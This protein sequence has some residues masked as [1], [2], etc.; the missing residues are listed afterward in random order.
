M[1]RNT[2]LFA[3]LA[4]GGLQA[5][6]R[7]EREMAFD[8]DPA[9]TEIDFTLGDLLHTVHGTF[10][11]KSGS[12]RLDPATQKA[13]GDITVDVASGSSGSSARDRKMHNDILQSQTYPEAVFTPR[14]FEGELV[15]SGVS[16]LK[17][18]GLFKIHGA[19]HEMTLPIH[20]ETQ[21]DQATATAHF[22]VPY[23]KWG[24]KNPSTFILRV[25][26]KVE[27]EIR[28][29]GMALPPIS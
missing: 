22:V 5:A 3:L 4:W 17:V 21:A 11:L 29:T 19:E 28:A 9:K 23:V 12:I 27:I 13:S 18:H 8:L 25:S 26:D 20:V 2:V 14:T 1:L 24:M 15:P 16:D 7:L 10:K 6:P